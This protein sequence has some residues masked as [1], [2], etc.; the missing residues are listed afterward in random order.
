[1]ALTI[2]LQNLPPDA[3]SSNV[4]DFFEGLHIADGGVHITNSYDGSVFIT[5]TSGGDAQ[6]GMKLHNRMF[7][8]E[9]VKLSLCT[10]EEK[11]DRLRSLEE[12]EQIL[13]DCQMYED[14]RYEDDRTLDRYHYEDEQRQPHSRSWQSHPLPP[15]NQH[16][17][18]IEETSWQKF[19]IHITNIDRSTTE[20]GLRE[21]LQGVVAHIPL[22]GIILKEDEY[23]FSLSHAYVELDNRRAFEISLKLDDSLV[24]GRR[25]RIERCS[26]H[27]F[28]EH[29]NRFYVRIQNI[30]K[31]ISFDGLIDFLRGV[32]PFIPKSR[33]CLKQGTYLSEAY[34]QLI[35]KRAFDICLKMDD[36]LV[37]GRRVVITAC[38]ERDFEENISLERDGS[39][40][41]EEWNPQ[42][43]D[44]HFIERQRAKTYH[45]RLQNIDKSVTV[46]DVRQF[47]GVWASNMPRGGVF[48][49]RQKNQKTQAFVE[50]D[51][52][53]AMKGLLAMKGQPLN[54]RPVK[55]IH[56][57][58]QVF[59]ENRKVGTV[60]HGFYRPG[61]ERGEVQKPSV[62][63]ENS[64]FRDDR[65]VERPPGFV[66][67]P[68]R[69]P[70]HL[71]QDAPPWVPGRMQA[72]KNPASNAGSVSTTSLTRSSWPD[73]QHPQQTQEHPGE[74]FVVLSNLLHGVTPP[75]IRSIFSRV[76]DLSVKDLKIVLDDENK[77]KRMAY[78]RVRSQRSLLQ[79]L[80]L[81]NVWYKGAQVSVVKCTA[82]DFYSKQHL[83]ASPPKKEE[84][85]YPFLFLGG[86]DDSVSPKDIRNV[87]GV[88]SCSIPSDGILIRPDVRGNGKYVAFVR[89]EDQ[90]IL[91]QA[92][93]IWKGIDHRIQINGKRVFISECSKKLVG[94]YNLENELAQFKINP[95]T[96]STKPGGFLR[97]DGGGR[98]K[99][100]DNMTY[101]RVYE[102]QRKHMYSSQPATYTTSFQSGGVFSETSTAS[103]SSSSLSE[104]LRASLAGNP[105]LNLLDD[106]PRRRSRSP[107]SRDSRSRSRSP[108]QRRSASQSPQWKSRSRGTSQSQS[109]SWSRSRSPS[110]SRSRS[111]NWSRSRSPNRSRSR[112]QSR[113]RSR[114]P[115]FEEDR[116][117]P[118]RRR[119]RS[120]LS[121]SF[122]R[123]HERFSRSRSRSR[124]RSA[125][126]SPPRSMF[127]DD[128]IHRR[129]SGNAPIIKT[130]SRFVRVSHLPSWANELWIC[131]V[132]SDCN[133]N[134]DSILIKYLGRSPLHAYVECMTD[135]DFVMAIKHDGMVFGTET[136]CVEPL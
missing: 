135:R 29:Q 40:D 99:N 91:A 17:S 104:R 51:S 113:S 27:E 36:S 102:P 72:S 121:G 37:S 107:L 33:I 119:S 45:V 74:C 98:P 106:E 49:L 48:F 103:V 116:R 18:E 32:A 81:D 4:R 83:E 127:T 126:R 7:F 42:S 58:K 130:R 86:L 16:E 34:V 120:P 46:I 93:V 123:R 11:C 115:I 5:F 52:E 122:E 66:E 53:E 30:D 9:R 129:E 133:I 117:S 118:V 114:S 70:R 88:L 108:F 69:L 35:N 71:S 14:T 21:F 22:G 64:S 2:H 28:V 23:D 13:E 132:F 59:D 50:V 111:P 12:E 136:I 80:S 82:R 101:M 10:E 6:A 8:G 24:D 38:S 19:Y 87:F 31:S 25:I 109:R 63:P 78:I 85:E 15:G 57:T 54:G 55:V 3:T 26:R 105:G 94:K 77:T 61:A 100:H 41:K 92:Q 44:V 20:N 62:P 134:K 128:Q 90:E 97:R 89:F 56:C 75:E 79:M 124:G 131:D 1:M 68:P 39:W 112:S 96:A 67:R 110:R 43:D 47:A 60:K 65:F 95:Q 73:V 76:I 84:N 125:S